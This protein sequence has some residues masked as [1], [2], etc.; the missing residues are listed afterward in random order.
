[1]IFE[2]VEAQD[3]ATALA[4]LAEYFL[5]MGQPQ[6][7]GPVA[8]ALKQAFPSELSALAG[9]LYVEMAQRDATAVNATIAAIQ[10]QL[11]LKADEILPWERRVSLALALAQARQLP[12]ARPLLAFSLETV[13]E[14]HLRSLTAGTLYRLLAVARAAD[15]AWPDESLRTDALAL[16]PPEWR[17]RL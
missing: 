11:D 1:M 9:R 14:D 13:D 2:V 7:A 16:L 15:L 8:A 6:L 17:D 3:N 10:A 4:R 12:L 5:E